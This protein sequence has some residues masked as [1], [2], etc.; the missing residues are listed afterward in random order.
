MSSTLELNGRPRAEAPLAEG[1]R[2]PAAAGEHLQEDLAARQRCAARRS[3]SRRAC[4][5][6]R[7]Q[8]CITRTSAGSDS[9]A[10]SLNRI[11]RPS[12]APR[13][14]GARDSQFPLTKYRRK[15]PVQ[16]GAVGRAHGIPAAEIRSPRSG[17]GTGATRCGASGRQCGPTAAASGVGRCR[18]EPGPRTVCPSSS[19]PVSARRES[20][21]EGLRS[22]ST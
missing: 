16:N 9:K 1:G 20:A 17:L 10:K 4:R 21:S 7:R 11:R 12:T 18:P 15:W 14:S 2:G 6:S 22:V 19:S 3:S 8:L 5:P 13:G